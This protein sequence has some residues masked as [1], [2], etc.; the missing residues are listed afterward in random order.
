MLP[1][2]TWVFPP[3][4]NYTTG[5][6]IRL[7]VCLRVV[8]A[9]YAGE[10]GE[11]GLESSSTHVGDPLRYRLESGVRRP[12]VG[13]RQLWLGPGLSCWPFQSMNPRSS[14]KHT[15][16]GMDRPRQCLF[17]SFLDGHRHWCISTPSWWASIYTL[18]WA[19]RVLGVSLAECRMNT[20]ACQV[21]GF[22]TPL[23]LCIRPTPL[24]GTPLPSTSFTK[25]F[26]IYPTGHSHF[27]ANLS[28]SRVDSL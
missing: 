27:S 20:F 25:L 19:A 8:C 10:T 21:L 15:G 11:C 28:T 23:P 5:V 13:R 24:P 14:G 4:I 12:G 7:G 18:P 1:G 17:G 26:P 6:H 22:P 9:A 2:L 16:V 3:V